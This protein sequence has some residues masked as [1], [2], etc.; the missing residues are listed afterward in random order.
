MLKNELYKCDKKQ[1][2]L[3]NTIKKKALECF[4]LGMLPKE[5]C[6][7]I[8]EL[9]MII[10]KSYFDFLERSCGDF[11]R[12]KGYYHNKENMDKGNKMF[13]NALNIY[14]AESEVN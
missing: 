8:Y 6:K 10:N 12:I 1:M 3:L 13:L 7:R 14:Y 11:L 2:K 5:L 4:S 9:D